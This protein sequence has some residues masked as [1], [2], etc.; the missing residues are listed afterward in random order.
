M[1]NVS[2]QEASGR[3]VIVQKD[4]DEDALNPED[5]DEDALN[6]EEVKAFGRLAPIG[7]ITKLSKKS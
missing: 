2:G 7:S 5:A 4:N 1:I 6:L 3:Y